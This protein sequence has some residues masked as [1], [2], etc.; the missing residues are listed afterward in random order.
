M[1][2]SQLQMLRMVY[3]NTRD[4]LQYQEQFIDTKI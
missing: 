2:R 3:E 1:L 4:T